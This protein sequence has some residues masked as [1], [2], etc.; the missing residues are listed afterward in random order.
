MYYFMTIIPVYTSLCFWICNLVLMRVSGYN[1]QRTVKELNMDNGKNLVLSII[2][3]SMFLIICGG[4]VSTT[5]DMFSGGINV[6]NLS[7]NHVSSCATIWMNTLN[8]LVETSSVSYQTIQ[9]VATHINFEH[10]SY[11]LILFSFYSNVKHVT[12]LW[13]MVTLTIKNQQWCFAHD[14]QG[15]QR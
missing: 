5:V 9:L 13:Q 7:W 12:G 8:T 14:S 11:C 15:Y 6:A 3:H 4:G 2:S 1:A 10:K